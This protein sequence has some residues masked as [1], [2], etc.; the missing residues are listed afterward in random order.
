[1]RIGHDQALK[2]SDGP[3]V[4]PIASKSRTC[5]DPLVATH[6]SHAGSNPDLPSTAMRAGTRR[7]RVALPRRAREHCCATCSTVSTTLPQHQGE[8]GATRL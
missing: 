3:C 4:P 6:E 8:E 7:A 2:Q 1:M 5:C